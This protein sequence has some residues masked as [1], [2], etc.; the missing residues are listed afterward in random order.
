M[1][2]KEQRR[3]PE[4]AHFAHQI[5]FFHPL[6]T[7]LDERMRQVGL[8]QA[9]VN[10]SASFGP[11]RPC[12]GVMTEKHR[13]A[14][15]EVEPGYWMTLKVK[16]GYTVRTTKD[17]QKQVEYS[18]TIG[19]SVLRCILQRCYDM[20][21]LFSKSLTEIEATHS[22]DIVRQRLDDVFVRYLDR[23]NFENLDI[24]EDLGGITYLTL[25]QPSF[26]KILSFVNDIEQ[27]FP[28]VSGVCIL[29]R[30]YVV[31]SGLPSVHD[32]RLF[33]DYITNPETGKVDDFIVNQVKQKGEAVIS[34][35]RMNLLPPTVPEKDPSLSTNVGAQASSSAGS[36]AP[37][38]YKK[39]PAPPSL[40]SGFI[41]GPEEPDSP[42]LLSTQEER[43]AWGAKTL[44]VGRDRREYKVVSYQFEEETTITLF[45]DATNPQTDLSPLYKP[46]FYI[47]LRSM[48]NS[49]LP[50][51]TQ[52]IG[53]AW[54]K[55]KKALET[56]ENPYRYLFF[57]GISLAVRT[58]IGAVK[59]TVLSGEVVQAV[60]QIHSEMD[61]MDLNEVVLK[62][63]G[64][65]WIVGQRLSKKFLYV[66]LPKG[67]ALLT[68]IGEEMKRI[69]QQ[70]SE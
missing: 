9:L 68:E 32:L 8:A 5:A 39:A 63:S 65:L 17:G 26:L 45:C 62:T 52:L 31:Y 29:W 30:H 19:E 7:D 38:F 18:R 43:E 4:L 66:V 56:Q 53:E 33:F 13:M 54:L 35:R 20:F 23:L 50:V 3:P 44:Y 10:F 69:G 28:I 67:D 6:Y 36:M 2:E 55:S 24:L 46:D 27:R 47:S 12:E 37:F 25:Q 16:F 70:L 34:T 22:K 40:F 60:T 61:R 57:S 49:R 48:L 64:D 11:S 58:S 14:L 51:L 21:R 15:L 59:G 1:A 42:G 41:I